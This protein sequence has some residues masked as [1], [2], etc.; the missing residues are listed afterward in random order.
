MT[1]RSNVIVFGLFLC[2][3][4]QA[5]T[6]VY[7]EHSE[8]LN[9]DQARIADAQIL[10]GNVIFRH[11]DALMYC[12]SAYFYEK[13]NSIDAFGHVRFVQGDTLFGYGDKLFYDGNS[14]FARLR[15]NVRLVHG[16][17][18]PTILTTDS[19]N[20]DRIRDI[21]YYYTG[22]TIRDSLNTL[23]SVWGQYTPNTKQAV[24]SHTVHLENPK[25]DLTTDTLLYNTHTNV[26]DLISPTIIVYE[27]ETNIYSS[28]GWYNT[29]TEESMLLD[30]SQ[31][32][33]SDGKSMTGDTIFYNKRTRYGR[34]IGS[35]EMADTIQKATLYGNYGEMFRDGEYGYVTDSA[36][37]V[38]WS[39]SLACGYMHADTLFSEMVPYQIQR[40]I[41][42]DSVLIDSVLTAV[43]PD[44]LWQDSTYRAIRAFHNVRIYRED[45]QAVC[46]SIYYNQKDSLIAL[47]TAPVCWSDENQISADTIYIY[48]RNGTVDYAHGIGN[49]L[50]IKQETAD[51][52]DQM[53]G[54]EMIAYIRDNELRQ[55]D[56]NGNALTVFFPKEED[57]SFIGVNTTQSSFVKV[58]LENQKIHHIL[59]TAQTTGTLYPFDQLPEGKD[60]L[61]GFFWADQERPKHPKDVFSRPLRTLRP[62]NTAVS[63]VAT[64]PE[65]TSATDIPQEK[66]ATRSSRKLKSTK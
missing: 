58:Y 56:V 18:Y 30:R 25:F 21:A 63:A 33:H 38:D 62:G 12:D 36:L 65:T 32:V 50:T 29:A 31:V 15:R 2:L 59:F 61:N 22:G 34:I 57:G 9:F 51:Y 8:T 19:L 60:R 35:M 24:F 47:Y 17:D 3:G 48:M 6:M 23:R 1:F 44:T 20:Y 46:D 28:R 66:T 13:A 40:I 4:L 27:E 14:K 5:Q 7:L 10:R 52:F 26:A 45:M 41:P 64:E 49:A 53:A 39:D 55:V 43:A 11:E 42:R 16:K 37:M 54:K